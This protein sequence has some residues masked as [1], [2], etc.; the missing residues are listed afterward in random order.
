MSAYAVPFSHQH[1]LTR[2]GFA[3]VSGP[4]TFEIACRARAEQ[5]PHFGASTKRPDKR[6]IARELLGLKHAAQDTV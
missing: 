4:H 1:S 6:F 3:S 2:E 5:I